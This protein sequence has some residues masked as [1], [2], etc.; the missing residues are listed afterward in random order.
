VDSLDSRTHRPLRRLSAGREDVAGSPHA[1]PGARGGRRPLVKLLE[2]RGASGDASNRIAQSSLPVAAFLRQPSFLAPHATQ[3]RAAQLALP[4]QRPMTLAVRGS[5]QDARR[6]R[7]PTP[8]ATHPEASEYVRS[9]CTFD[10]KRPHRSQ[11]A[12]SGVGPD[13]SATSSPYR[14]RVYAHVYAR[15]R[16]EGVQPTPASWYPTGNWASLRAPD[17]GRS[18]APRVDRRGPARNILSHHRS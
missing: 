16:S 8:V 14:A 11:S 13:S 1:W 2:T 18:R 5:S 4:R 12:A 7:R 3:L 15:T 9:L 17:G 10:T 6:T